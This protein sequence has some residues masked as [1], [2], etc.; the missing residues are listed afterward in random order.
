MTPKQRVLDAL[1]HQEPDRIPLDL[2]GTV[3][4]GINRRALIRFLDYA[5]IPHGEIE[6]QDVAQQLGRVPEDILQRLGVD[7][8]ALDPR[9]GSAWR[10][11]I[12]RRGDSDVYYDEWGIGWRKPVDSDLCC[13]CHV[14]A[15]PPERHTDTANHFPPLDEYNE[16]YVDPLA[17]AKRV[18]KM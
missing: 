2:G 11:E 16:W 4:T 6:I 17:V 8:R 14:R 13:D 18:G 1:N 10:L 15:R 12:K 9:P 5:G 3:I 7:V